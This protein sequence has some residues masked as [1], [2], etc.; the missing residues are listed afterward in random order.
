MQYFNRPATFTR[1]KTTMKASLTNTTPTAIPPRFRNP[2][3]MI[4][5][6]V[7]VQTPLVQD[8]EELRD[9][10]VEAAGGRLVNLAEKWFFA[11]VHPGAEERPVPYE[12]LAELHG[13]HARH[14]SLNEP[15]DDIWTMNRLRSLSPALS[16]VSDPARSAHVLHM[17]L[18]LP[19]ADRARCF[20]LVL[21]AGCGLA[22]LGGHLSMVRAGVHESGWLGVEADPEAAVRADEL[23]R[24]LG[25]GEVVCVDPADPA[26]YG[27]LP[28]VDRILC[29]S[30]FGPL[31]DGSWHASLHAV[32]ALFRHAPGRVEHAEAHPEGV[33]AYSRDTGVS[34][35]LSRDTAFKCPVDYHPSSLNPQGLYQDDRVLPLHRL[36]EPFRSFLSFG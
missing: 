19:V 35:I 15:G 34:L 24:F 7:Y 17:L 4:A 9:S 23:S 8:V 11:F 13:L 14:K 30:V 21:G 5:E 33:I 31:R 26:A 25:L 16:L 20:G 3:G 2:A 29:P 32:Q 36:G 10:T 12:A 28:E 1:H 6:D 27:P 18:E 22:M